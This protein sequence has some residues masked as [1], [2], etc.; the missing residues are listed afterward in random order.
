MQPAPSHSLTGPGPDFGMWSQR[1]D[2]RSD[3]SGWAADAT[4]VRGRRAVEGTTA[5]M[6]TTATSPAPQPLMLVNN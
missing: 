4:R 2:K 1:D 6:F 3:E 5:E